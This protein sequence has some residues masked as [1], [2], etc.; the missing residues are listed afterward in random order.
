[1]HDSLWDGALPVLEENLEITEEFITK[2][3]IDSTLFSEAIPFI[4][5]EPIT[6]ELNPQYDST[7]TTLH[8]LSKD[9]EPSLE[10]PCL[11]IDAEHIDM[12]SKMYTEIENLVG[13]SIEDIE[14]IDTQSS[15]SVC[16]SPLMDN[17][18]YVDSPAITPP[19]INLDT[20]FPSISCL[21]NSTPPI[22]LL[23]QDSMVDFTSATPSSP[24]KPSPIPSKC[25][26]AE[27]SNDVIITNNCIY[28]SL[29]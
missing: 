7:I 21:L 11:D 28:S 24:T 10:M 17:P 22:N 27:H 25:I 8:E 9:T 4:L 2:E 5:H 12:N 20:I 26:P 19:S 6:I 1:M 16:E 13:N 14:V 23:E 29:F 3:F 18:D 15:T